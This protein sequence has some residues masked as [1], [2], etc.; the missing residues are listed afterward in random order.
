MDGEG[1]RGILTSLKILRHAKAINLGED[2]GVGIDG[3]PHSG[4]PIDI[5]AQT[6][7][8]E[9]QMASKGVV[10]VQGGTYT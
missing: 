2:I 6:V 3:L 9:K 10:V 1:G 8:M 5:A 4:D 7:S